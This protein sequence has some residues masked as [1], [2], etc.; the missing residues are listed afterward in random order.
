MPRLLLA[1]L[2][3]TLMLLPKPGL[4]AAS[5]GDNPCAPKKE[6]KAR[7]RVFNGRIKVVDKSAIILEGPK[8]QTFQITSATKINKAGKPATIADLK[9]GDTVGGYAREMPDGK[10]GTVTLNVRAAVAKEPTATP[11]QK[12][13]K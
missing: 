1:T 12:P 5:S 6:E 2:V 7:G 9:P 11:K 8:A 10:W 3:A 4:A 13:T